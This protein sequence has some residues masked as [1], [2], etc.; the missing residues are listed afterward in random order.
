MSRRISVTSAV[1]VLAMLGLVG[2]ASPAAALAGN[3]IVVTTT[4]QAAVDWAATTWLSA[5]TACSATTRS[6]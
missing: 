5:T 2:I 3:T 6:A 1:I 4:I